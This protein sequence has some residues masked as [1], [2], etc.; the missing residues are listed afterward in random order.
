[1]FKIRILGKNSFT[2]RKFNICEMLYLFLIKPQIQLLDIYYI[3]EI[4]KS[5]NFSYFYISNIIFVLRRKVLI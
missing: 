3:T 5:N 1:M 4:L 2:V